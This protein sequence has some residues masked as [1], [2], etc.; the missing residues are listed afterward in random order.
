MA[1][2]ILPRAQDVL[3]DMTASST[4]AQMIS[5]PQCWTMVMRA[6]GQRTCGPCGPKLACQY[7]TR[8]VSWRQR[9]VETILVGFGSRIQHT[10]QC[11]MQV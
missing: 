1:S 9:A 8:R 6:A 10:C 4:A 7:S 3:G 11:I 5:H 2:T